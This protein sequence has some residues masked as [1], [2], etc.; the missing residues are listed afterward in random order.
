MTLSGIIIKCF[1]GDCAEVDGIVLQYVMPLR[2]QAQTLAK[3]LS[4]QEKN[5]HLRRN[6][7]NIRKNM[8][9]QTFGNFSFVPQQIKNMHK[10]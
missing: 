10:I 6:S 5:A 9:H 8:M 2:I 1:L 4:G 3:T 7:Q